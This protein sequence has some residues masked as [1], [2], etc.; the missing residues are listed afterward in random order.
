VQARMNSVRLPGKVLKRIGDRPILGH[1]ARRLK[2]SR[3]LHGVIIATSDKKHDDPI[4]RFA[5]KQGIKLFRGS[6]DNVLKRIVDCAE[7]YNADV[8]VRICADSPFI[9]P[10]LVDAF[11]ASFK[12]LEPDYL[13]CS[14]GSVPHG[15]ECEVISLAALKRSLKQAKTKNDLEHVSWF[16]LRHKDDFKVKLIRPEHFRN[17][18]AACFT[19]DEEEDLCFAR[20]LYAH[21][22]SKE[23]IFSTEEIFKVLKEHPKLLAINHKITRNKCL[24]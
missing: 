14:D 1:I 6:S 16:I 8:V 20:R 5:Y 21:I 13:S 12:R 22:G 10:H 7:L 17:L 9:D 15:L 4:A 2:A 19:V 11:I 23:R 3:Y 18:P 24:R